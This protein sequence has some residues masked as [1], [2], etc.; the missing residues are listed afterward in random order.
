MWRAPC[1]WNAGAGRQPAQVT[2]TAAGRLIEQCAVLCRLYS[3][4]CMKRLCMLIFITSAARRGASELPVRAAPRFQRCDFCRDLMLSRQAR[5]QG[6]GTSHAVI[7]AT[8]R[9]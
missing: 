4:V 3:S 5:R 1:G 6:A 7:S 2:A 8:S 9:R